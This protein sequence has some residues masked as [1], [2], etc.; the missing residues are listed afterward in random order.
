MHG[1]SSSFWSDVSLYYTAFFRRKKE[2]CKK[3]AGSAT[4]DFS[5]IQL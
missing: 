5:I 3:V 1:V 4:G 2:V